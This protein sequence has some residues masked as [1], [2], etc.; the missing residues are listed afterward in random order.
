MTR[1]QEL[2]NALLRQ[3]GTNSVMDFAGISERHRQLMVDLN[4]RAARGLGTLAPHPQQTID[5]EL[6]E[7]ECVEFWTRFNGFHFKKKR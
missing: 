5:T 3:A 7:E 4:R 6:S 1:L 2:K